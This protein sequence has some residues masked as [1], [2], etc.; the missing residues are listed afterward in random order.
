MNKISSPSESTRL[1]P[2]TPATSYDGAVAV[3]RFSIGL[4]RVVNVLVRSSTSTCNSGDFF[5]RKVLLFLGILDD[6]DVEWM[7]GVGSRREIA[8]GDALV[9]EGQQLD[10]VF[11]VIDG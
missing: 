5:M 11:L 4:T 2:P 3:P 7:I 8:V 6:S 10:S 9:Q 1:E